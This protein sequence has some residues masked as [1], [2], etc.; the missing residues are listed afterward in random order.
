MIA[1]QQS[2]APAINPAALTTQQV[3]ERLLTLKR[4][5]SKRVVVERI[6]A[7]IPAKLKPLL[8]PSRYKGVHGGRGSSKSHTFAR[9]LLRR[10]KKNPGTRWVCVREIQI[11]LQQSVKRLLEDMIKLYDLGSEFEV[12][13]TLIKTPG[14]GVIIFQGMQNHTA[15]SIKSLEGFDGVWVEEAQTLSKTSLELLRPTIRKDGSE[16]WFSWNPEKRTDPVEFLRVAPPADAIIIE[17]NWQDNP[18]FPPVL[19]TEMEGDYERD[20]EAAAHVWGGKYKIRSKASVF[21]NWRMARFATPDDAAFLFGSDW[22]FSID[23]TV[24]IRGFV[25]EGSFRD[26]LVRR[27]G[28]SGANQVL[29]IDAAVWKVGCE[30]DDTPALFDT[31]DPKRPG[32]AREWKIIADSARPETIS[33]M[34]RHGYPRVVPARKGA[35]SVEEGIKFLQQYDIIIHPDCCAQGD[36]G[37]NHVEDEFLNYRYKTHPLTGEVMPILEDKKNHTID[38]ARYM[39]ED[40]AVDWVTW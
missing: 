31:L 3:S 34:Q 25:A 21:K 23:P 12:Q 8:Q 26:E 18:H 1:T 39:V 16:L 15:D 28:L 17:M 10:C 4:E 40:M 30:I 36:D 29:C 7:S 14:D 27:L 19:R 20:P 24:L 35:G 6:E 33:F 11:S 5:L 32:M 9:L 38:A 2:E 37:I 13:N 22:G